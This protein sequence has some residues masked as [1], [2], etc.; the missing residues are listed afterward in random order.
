MGNS[1]ARKG[2]H[3]AGQLPRRLDA[4]GRGGAMPRARYRPRG[5]GT[6]TGETRPRLW[7][8]GSSDFCSKTSGGSEGTRRLASLQEIPLG[9]CQILRVLRVLYEAQQVRQKDPQDNAYGAP[10]G[11]QENGE[12][13]VVDEDDSDDRREHPRYDAHEGIEDYHNATPGP[14]GVMAVY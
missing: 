13:D 9:L 2:P 8:G 1:V 5:L 10:E 7:G 14:P 4:A 6:P 3:E 12:E 11:G